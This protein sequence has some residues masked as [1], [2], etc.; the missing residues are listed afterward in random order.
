MPNNLPGYMY[1]TQPTLS[2]RQARWSEYLQ[3][4]NFAWVH[5]PGKHNVADPLSRNLTFKLNVVLAVVIRSRNKPETH[6]GNTATDA[7]A[8]PR[9]RITT[10]GANQT[11]LGSTDL[12]SKIL[13]AYADDSYFANDALAKDLLQLNGICWQGDIIYVPDISD[14]KQQILKEL[15]DSPCAGH[16]CMLKLLPMSN[17]VQAARCRNLLMWPY[18]TAATPR[19]TSISLAHCHY[20]TGVPKTAKGNTVI[21][22]FVDKLTKYVHLIPCSKEKLLLIG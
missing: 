8:N 17:T 18:W 12:V 21:V 1:I 10:P 7:D 20:V 3:R 22:V 14:I 16:M 19:S 15:H 6:P 5:R 2:R 9:A 13:D 11:D 4:Y